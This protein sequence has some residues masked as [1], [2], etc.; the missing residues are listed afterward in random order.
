[1]WLAEKLC[2]LKPGSRFRKSARSRRR[3]CRQRMHEITG[4]PRSLLEE[5]KRRGAKNFYVTAN[6][7]NNA[8]TDGQP[9][10]PADTDY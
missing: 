4:L 1:M 8:G 5:L 6:A 2:A 7:Q 3:P 10:F 9:V